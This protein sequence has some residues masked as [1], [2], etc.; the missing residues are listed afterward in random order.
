MSLSQIELENGS[1]VAINDFGNPHGFPII[2]NHGMIASIKDESLFSTLIEAGRRIICIARPGYGKTSPFALKNVSMWGS[3]VHEVVKKIGIEEFDVL[4]L[5]SGAP[6]SYAIAWG[7]RKRTRNVYI[8]SGT[9]ALFHE[10]VVA[11]WPYPIN[12]ETKI[13]ELQTLAKEIFFPCGVE[14]NVSASVDSYMNDCFGIAL[15]LKI[16]CMNWGF[17]LSR[18][19]SN[20]IMEHGMDD[21]SIPYAA[22]EITAGLLENCKLK[23]RDSGGHF[24]AELL[25]QFFRD[26][27]LMQ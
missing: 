19:K 26:T 23:K 4:G 21:E 25:D 27:V 22:A 24:T 18:L 20:V 10:D 12:P 6:Y 1:S 8:F 15:D 17:E 3:V 11:L 14:N 13:P 5:S 9:P 7:L 2:V 16:R